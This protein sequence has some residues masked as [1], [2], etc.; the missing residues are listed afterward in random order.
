MEPFEDWYDDLVELARAE[1]LLCLVS[2][3]PEDHRES[4]EDGL[5]PDEELDEQKYAASS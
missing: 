1:D 4:Y 5:T 2:N 3:Y